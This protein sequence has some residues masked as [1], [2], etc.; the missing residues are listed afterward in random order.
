MRWPVPF[1]T[2]DLGDGWTAVA[3]ADGLALRDEGRRGTD[4][5][6]MEGLAHCVGGYT[7]ACQTGRSLVI[8]LRHGSGVTARRVSTL[9]LSPQTDGEIKI[10]TR[11][12]RLK[13]H[14]AYR[15]KAAPPEAEARLETLFAMLARNEIPVREEALDERKEIETRA[16]N[17]EEALELMPAWQRVLPEKVADLDADGLRAFLARMDAGLPRLDEVIPPRPPV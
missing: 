12:Y 17:R 13:Q 3:L 16:M 9:E 10:S 6:G 11:H 14:R 1:D 15:N 2:V 5:G 4:R 7:P 8:S